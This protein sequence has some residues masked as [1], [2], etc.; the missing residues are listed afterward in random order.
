MRR[1]V[2]VAGAVLVLGPLVVLVFLVAPGRSAPES[3]DPAAG[4]GS[5]S[6][7]VVQAQARRLLDRAAAA[8]GRTSYSGVQFVSAWTS[9]GTTSEVVQV[10][11]QPGLGTTVTSDA[12]PSAPARRRTLAAPGTPSIADGGA[13]GVL[14]AHYSLSVVGTGQVAGRPVDVVAAR[15]P[16]TAPGAQEAARFWLDQDTGLVLRREV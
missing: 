3:A 10:D 2:P 12:S 13:V 5:G 9:H 14:A 4:S 8:P 15:R 7:P 16:G 1:S 11:H 6:P